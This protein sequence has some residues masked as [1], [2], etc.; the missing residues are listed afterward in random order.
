[1]GMAE[2]VG[3]MR[4]TFEKVE[5]HEEIINVDILPRIEKIEKSQEELVKE[6]AAM[7]AS[8]TNL[9]LTV[10]KE[11]QTTRQ[12]V[13]KLEG[14]LTTQS[15]NLFEIVKSAMGIQST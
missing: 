9:E 15:E 4:E 1:M 10:M 8:Q 12:V 6:V 11:S 14:T 5:Q 2:G 3:S 7:R 13:D